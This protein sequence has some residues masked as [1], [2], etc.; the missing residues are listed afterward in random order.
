MLLGQ[1]TQH[2]LLVF[3]LPIDEDGLDVVE[4]LVLDETVDFGVFLLVFLK[5]QQN[6]ENVAVVA[7]L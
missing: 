1:P 7:F 6:I 2:S 4:S 5:E 3:C